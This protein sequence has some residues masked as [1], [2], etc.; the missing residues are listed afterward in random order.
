MTP[1]G[2]GGVAAW[3]IG[4]S[5]R[6]GTRAAGRRSTPRRCGCLGQTG[7][8]ARIAQRR[9]AGA[10]QQPA[11]MAGESVGR[12]VDF[13]LPVAGTGFAGVGAPA[14]AS[15]VVAAQC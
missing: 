6:E 12:I 15:A 8:L 5:E 11:V 13:D 14:T 3:L 10:E 1:A 4:R 9:P 2:K 7:C